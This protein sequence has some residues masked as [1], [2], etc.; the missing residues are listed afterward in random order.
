MPARN[1]VFWPEKTYPGQKKRIPA[2]IRICRP[3]PIN[4]GPE[5]PKAGPEMPMQIRD[6]RMLARAS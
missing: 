6:S 1:S 2:R 4:A 5:K 3:E